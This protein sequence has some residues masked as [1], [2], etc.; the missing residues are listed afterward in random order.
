MMFG[1]GRCQLGG[2][3]STLNILE[4]RNGIFLDLTGLERGPMAAKTLILRTSDSDII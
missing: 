4:Q 3:R 2:A 1:G